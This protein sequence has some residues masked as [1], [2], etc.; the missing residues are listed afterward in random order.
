MIE[1]LG[2]LAVLVLNLTGIPLVIGC[3]KNRVELPTS[4][5]IWCLVGTTL[6]LSYL[7]LA[8]KG[9]ILISGSA[10]SLACFS[11]VFIAKALAQKEN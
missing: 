3:F 6:M 9:W 11:T 10:F 2:I 8:E 7:V 1:L 5:I 4:F